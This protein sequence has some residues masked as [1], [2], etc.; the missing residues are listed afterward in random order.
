MSTLAGKNLILALINYVMRVFS[1]T[2]LPL[3]GA[4][5]S[6]RGMPPLPTH[7]LSPAIEDITDNMRA[8]IYSLCAKIGQLITK[9]LISNY[10]L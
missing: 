4:T 9:L 2:T 5:Q 10:T 3:V 7:Q 1:G 6:G 8:K